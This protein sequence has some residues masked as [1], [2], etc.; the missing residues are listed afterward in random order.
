[1]KNIIFSENCYRYIIRFTFADG[2]GK[3]ISSYFRGLDVDIHSTINIWSAE[4]FFSLKEA[5]EVLA[6]CNVVWPAG[7]GK[8]CKVFMS[9]PVEL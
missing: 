7:H 5:Q 2:N 3:W 1:M 9:A 4:K 6:S 8:I